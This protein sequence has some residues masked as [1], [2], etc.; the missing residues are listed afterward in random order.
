M[1]K[2]IKIG[3]ICISIRK[4]I[5]TIKKSFGL[6]KYMCILC[7]VMAMSI[8]LAVCFF[9]KDFRTV[10]VSVDG[11]LLEITTRAD[12]VSEAIKD[13]GILLSGEDKVNFDLKSNLDDVDGVIS[14]SRPITLHVTMA[15]QNKVIKTYTDNVSDALKENG[16]HVGGSD[17]IIG[18]ESDGTANDGDT[19]TVVIV[20]TKVVEE[21]FSVP[22]ET[23]YVEDATLYKGE[24]EIAVQGQNGSVERKYTVTYEDGVEV[25]RELI[26]EVKTEPVNQVIAVGT[27]VY[28]TNNRGFNDSYSKAYDMT[29]TAYSPTPENWGYATSSGNRARDGVVAVDTRIIPLGTRLYIK[30]NVPGIPDYGYCIAWDTGGAIKNMRVDLF[31]ESEADCVKFGIRDVTVYIL[32]DQTVDV[33]ALR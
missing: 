1:R 11:E 7:G 33:F 10:T 9:T 19:I 17:Q 28:F 31:M 5:K 18:G 2:K 29:A 21:K 8:C 3:E 22:Y 32:E 12:T 25:S 4:Q 30:S 15:G 24:S 13:A 6:V 16:I 23:V 26:S 14:V 20:S 27:K